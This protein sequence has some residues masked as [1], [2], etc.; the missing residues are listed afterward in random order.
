M[1]TKWEFFK[2]R[3]NLFKPYP[4]YKKKTDKERILE[5]LE[6]REKRL[7]RLEGL[8]DQADIVR[9]YHNYVV[10]FLSFLL[11]VTIMMIV[12]YL[13]L[14]IMPDTPIFGG[15]EN[16][17]YLTFAHLM[18]AFF[19]MWWL[20]MDFPGFRRRRYRRLGY[21]NKPFDLSEWWHNRRYYIVREEIEKIEC[22]L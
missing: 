8:R 21:S 6:S 4:N 20:G 1:T 22:K 12:G 13:I 15:E 3:F 18:V 5:G 16:G 7:K 10:M 9:Y 14:N 11:D 2:W 17:S 19:V